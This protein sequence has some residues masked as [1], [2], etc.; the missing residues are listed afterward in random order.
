[1][2][3]DKA[4]VEGV[5]RFWKWGIELMKGREGNGSGGLSVGLG[6]GWSRCKG[7]LW[8]CSQGLLPPPPLVRPR[9]WDRVP[10]QW[11]AASLVKPLTAL[12]FV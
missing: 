1:M 4:K 11:W 5:I 8:F 6:L 12:A 10:R 9:L 7:H 3:D 2:P